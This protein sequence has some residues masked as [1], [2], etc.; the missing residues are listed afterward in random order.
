MS[1]DWVDRSLGSESHEMCRPVR[2]ARHE[3]GLT[4]GP[5]HGGWA[6]D[7]ELHCQRCGEHI[8]TEHTFGAAIELIRK[9]KK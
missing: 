4:I 5:R 3:V 2:G 1:E 9:R 7:Y 6:E 8:A